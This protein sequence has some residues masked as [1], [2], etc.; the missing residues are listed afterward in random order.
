[1]ASRIQPKEATL[2]TTGVACL[3]AAMSWILISSIYVT[4]GEGWPNFALS[5]F[6]ALA[7]CAVGVS[8]LTYAV[9]QQY[10]VKSSLFTD[11]EPN[12]FDCRPT[13][14]WAGECDRARPS[15]SSAT[16]ALTRNVDDC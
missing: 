16:G 11:H 10:V 6:S 3:V 2:A 9:H 1:M 5:V 12:E 8:A 14:Q 7:V 15:T 4:D 13:G